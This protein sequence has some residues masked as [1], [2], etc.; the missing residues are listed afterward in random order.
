[1]A[2][3]IFMVFL[4]GV[5]HSSGSQA[6]PR[7]ARYGWGGSPRTDETLRRLGAEQPGRYGSGYPEVNVR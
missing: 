6:L 3:R 7:L 5:S 1:M 2:T 4:L